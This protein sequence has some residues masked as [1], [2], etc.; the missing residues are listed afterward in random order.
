[1]HKRQ[2]E[3]ERLEKYKT[4]KIYKLENDNH[5]SG[6]SYTLNTITNE[7]NNISEDPKDLQSYW[8]YDTSQLFLKYN[9]EVIGIS[10]QRKVRKVD[11]PND[12]YKE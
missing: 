1:M 4:Y 11:R 10:K 9:K 8:I 7:N 12:V 2:I 3:I 5:G 6:N